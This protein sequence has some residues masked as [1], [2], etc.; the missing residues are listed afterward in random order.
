MFIDLDVFDRNLKTNLGTRSDI[1]RNYY[2]HSPGDILTLSQQF[3][4]EHICGEQRNA[5]CEEMPKCMELIAY[6]FFHYAPNNS[7]RI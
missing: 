3:K 2:I 6:I 1:H 4:I 7:V 5:E